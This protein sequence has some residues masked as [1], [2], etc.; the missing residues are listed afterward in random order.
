MNY[1]ELKSWLTLRINKTFTTGEE[2]DLLFQLLQ[3]H[4]RYNEWK[5][6]IPKAFKIVMKKAIQLHVLFNKYRIVSWVNC[7]KKRKVDPLASAMRH[8]IKRQITIYKKNHLD[9]K[10]VLCESLNVEVDHV[11]KFVILKNNYI[12]LYSP[13]TSFNYHSKYGHY[14]FKKADNHWKKEWQKYHLKN[15]TYRYLYSSCNKKN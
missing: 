10:C 7:V 12:N 3:K 11:I 4:P 15:A 2:Y 8:A 5:F 13:P 14:M 9:K 6:K 1:N